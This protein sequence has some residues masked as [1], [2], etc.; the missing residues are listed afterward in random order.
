[1][2]RQ[3]RMFSDTSA[4]NPVAEQ[5]KKRHPQQHHTPAKALVFLDCKAGTLRL[6]TLEPGYLLNGRSKN[7]RGVL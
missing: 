6:G 4:H 3:T 2:A 5:N 1:M 7:K